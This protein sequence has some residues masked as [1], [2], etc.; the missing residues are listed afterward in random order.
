MTG[1]ELMAVVG[2]FITVF[3]FIAA[4]FWKIWALIER[5]KTD[6]VDAAKK[7]AELASQARE[8]LSAHRLHVSEVYVTKAG[9]HEQT[10]QIMKSIEAIGDKI[11]RTNERLDRVFEQSK[12]RAR[13]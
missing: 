2:F 3:I 7:A 4:G 10:Q 9:M 12:P 5:A 13:A 1:A 6:A 8:E 11:D